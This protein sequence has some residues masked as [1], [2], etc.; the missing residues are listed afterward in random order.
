[1]TGF[2]VSKSKVEK[3]LEFARRL[4]AK[5]CHEQ[6]VISID[7]PCEEHLDL[8]GLR[9]QLEDTKS[10]GMKAKFT[11]NPSHIEIIN[12]V[13]YPLHANLDVQSAEQFKITQNLKTDPSA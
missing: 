5:K 4:F 6:G 7:T 1:M 2:E 10:Y 8:K 9:K 13:L 12:E 11:I 3:E